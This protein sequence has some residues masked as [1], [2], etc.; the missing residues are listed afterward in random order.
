MDRLDAGK[1]EVPRIA[2]VEKHGGGPAIGGA[3]IP[4][5]DIDREELDEPPRS[6]I[7]CPPDQRRQLCP[8]VADR[9]LVHSPEGI[10]PGR[11][12]LVKHNG[13]YVILRVCY[14]V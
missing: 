8:R 2:P 6:Q 11:A 12:G 14:T 7:P 3:G 1:S 9:Q 4:V 5:A 10:R 13:L